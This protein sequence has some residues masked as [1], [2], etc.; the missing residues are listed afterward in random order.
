[1]KFF[2]KRAENERDMVVAYNYSLTSD[3]PPK[4]AISTHCARL[5]PFE[6]RQAL[7]FQASF[8]QSHDTPMS[9]VLKR[10]V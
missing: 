4:K 2:V 5:V 8:T 1:M 9:L 10:G 3:V 6:A 7:I